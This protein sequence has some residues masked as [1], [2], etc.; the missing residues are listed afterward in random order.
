MT[1]VS[2]LT[3]VLMRYGLGVLAIAAAL[4]GS[5]DLTLAALAE[6]NLA[7]EVVVTREGPLA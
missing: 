7:N 6:Y 1:S 5:V 4:G 2:R 3:G